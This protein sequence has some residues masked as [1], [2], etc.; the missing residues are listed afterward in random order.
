MFC[1]THGLM[2]ATLAGRIVCAFLS[3]IFALT[4]IPVYAGVLPY[5]P[6]VGQM[7]MPANKPF[8]L[9]YIVG[10]R[11]SSE[12]IFKFTFILNRGDVGLREDLLR[13]HV[14]KVGKYFLAALTIPEKDIWVN[15]SP[16]EQNRIIP[17][18]LGQTDLGKDLL[19]EDYVLKQLASSLTFPNSESGK[20]YWQSINGVEANNHSPVNN[21]TKIWIVPG[22]IKIKESSDRVVINQATL[23]VLTDEDYLATQKNN[24]VIASE[25]KQSQPGIATPRNGSVRNDAS[26]AMRETI[27]PLI[28]KEVNT[29][30]HFAHLR[31]LYYSII[32]ASWFKK[33]LK[34]TILNEVYFNQKKVKGADVDDPQIKDKIYN[35]YV[36]A[37]KA[38]VYNM[39]KTER[40]GMK[41]S[42]R[43]YFSGGFDLGD[44]TRDAAENAER[45]TTEEVDRDQTIAEK[46]HPFEA[47]ALEQPL[48]N[49]GQP[50]LTALGPQDVAL[51]EENRAAANASLKKALGIIWDISDELA[52]VV[53]RAHKLGVAEL[54]EVPD[55]KGGI[56]KVM[57][58]T[59]DVRE[60]KKDMVRS[61]MIR[62]LRRQGMP[63]A[64]IE[65][66]AE[67]ASA[68][69]RR[70]AVMGVGVKPA[71]VG[72]IPAGEARNLSLGD[73]E[74]TMIQVDA[75]SSSGGS[76]A[77][78]FI[79]KRQG[80]R[81]TVDALLLG[82]TK[83]IG[84]GQKVYLNIMRHDPNNW[85]YGDTHIGLF[86]AAGGT[87]GYLVVECLP[88]GKVS[89]RN[90]AGNDYGVSLG[91]KPVSE[92]AVSS[93]PSMAAIPSSLSTL[94]VGTTTFTALINAIRQY[95][96]PRQVQGCPIPLDSD[97][98]KIGLERGSLVARAP[99]GLN[100]I[101]LLAKV[102][103]V[104]ADKAKQGL[105]Q[106]IYALKQ[107]GKIESDTVWVR[108]AG[109][110]EFTQTRVRYLVNG[111]LGGDIAEISETN[112]SVFAP[113]Q[114][115]PAKPATVPATTV[116]SEITA[117]DQHR[118]WL[119]TG[120]KDSKAMID[121]IQI[122]A[123]NLLAG[124]GEDGV[125]TVIK[126]NTAIPRATQYAFKTTEAKALVERVFAIEDSPNPPETIRVIKP[127]NTEPAE[128]PFTTDILTQVLAGKIIGIADNVSQAAA[129][130][131]Q[132][133][134]PAVDPVVDN[135]A[136]RLAAYLLRSEPTMGKEP[137]ADSGYLGRAPG[138]AFYRFPMSPE[139]ARALERIPGGIPAVKALVISKIKAQ[140]GLASDAAKG[141]FD[142]A[143][144][145]K[146][147][148]L[149]V[150]AGGVKLSGDKAAAYLSGG[151]V[152]GFK[153]AI[154][155]LRY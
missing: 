47:D 155:A 42:K 10:M 69:L 105:L 56:K 31:Q 100:G 129:L 39:I 9:P 95:P 96:G 115:T 126:F 55:G 104:V 124:L 7:I 116:P 82:T 98:L 40:V 146:N 80:D 148:E 125:L 24:L 67:E 8:D 48:D 72:E 137:G 13:H 128:E 73:G 150:T 62:E 41:I 43:Q 114:A 50:M 140:Q 121:G 22:T 18:E 119:A 130:P 131:A 15:L 6:P 143:G 60:A 38:G 135:Y 2:R 149:T 70:D 78:P 21:F 5:M 4:S 59:H 75:P 66:K 36:N 142:F 44:K 151:K 33:K 107:K 123:S 118:K 34:D 102:Q 45:G 113:A 147:S 89:I 111:V 11:F 153:L 12:D 17:Q 85:A 77:M 94:S 136:Q 145:Q 139:E 138:S 110:K 71:G 23:K 46:G 61:A 51:R 20:K 30:K 112:K 32:M 120:G 109:K 52:D 37:F 76:Y 35:E 87:H 25:A 84:P 79:I 49:A 141:G 27:V 1:L 57:G 63:D 83:N 74:E 133:V 19:G 103:I 3:I 53:Y 88:G 68:G 152:A 108:G 93:A 144:T 81:V 65:A 117:L 16:Y 64:G 99:L 28:E 29:G 134:A 90:N 86:D 122:W 127:G 58:F 132:S 97:Q 54:L 106:D 92:P 101:D 26:Q 154:L 91:E 14:D